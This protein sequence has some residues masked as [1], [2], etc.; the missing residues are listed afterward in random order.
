MYCFKSNNSNLY[1]FQ[2]N[3]L[4]CAIQYVSNLAL[5]RISSYSCAVITNESLDIINKLWVFC[6]VV[7]W[8]HRVSSTEEAAE[9]R[10]GET[11]QRS[12]SSDGDVSQ[13]QQGSTTLAQLQHL[14]QRRR[15]RKP[16]W[17]TNTR[18]LILINI[19]K[20]INLINWPNP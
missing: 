16:V 2:Y 13:G 7:E 17:A 11:T 19:I 1:C 14:M 20:I 4:F 10:L 5:T 12:D 3:I 18:S 6:G 9:S 8:L 15:L